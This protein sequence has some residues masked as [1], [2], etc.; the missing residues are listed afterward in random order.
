M[1]VNKEFKD[2]KLY[3]S[4][5]DTLKYSIIDKSNRMLDIPVFD[6][7]KLNLSIF[8]DFCEF[9]SRILLDLFED[10]KQKNPSN[11]NYEIFVKFKKGYTEEINNDILRGVDDEVIDFKRYYY[12]KIDYGFKKHNENTH[13]T[14]IQ[15]VVKHIEDVHNK[16]LEFSKTN[17]FSDTF[18]FILNLEKP[19]EEYKTAISVYAV[20]YLYDTM[21][22]ISSTDIQKHL[23]E[24]VKNSRILLNNDVNFAHF[25]GVI[26]KFYLQNSRENFL[27]VKSEKA[28]NYIGELKI[29]DVINYKEF[30]NSFNIII[31]LWLFM[32]YQNMKTLEI[33]TTADKLKNKVS[34]IEDS[35][36]IVTIIP[37][38]NREYEK[39]KTDNEYNEKDIYYSVVSTTEDKSNENTVVRKIYEQSSINFDSIIASMTEEKRNRSVIS[40]QANYHYPFLDSI[41]N[42]NN[43]QD[44]DF[45]RLLKQFEVIY[46]SYD[47]K[48]LHRILFD[49]FYEIIEEGKKKNTG[50]LD[51]R[52]FIISSLAQKFRDSGIT[53]VRN[54]EIRQNIYIDKSHPTLKEDDTFKK[55]ILL[56]N[57]KLVPSVSS[58]YEVMISKVYIKHKSRELIPHAHET[59]IDFI[60]D[61]VMFIFAQ[62]FKIF[63]DTRLLKTHNYIEDVL[64]NFTDILN[65]DSLSDEYSDDIH[66]DFNQ[67]IDM[68]K[69]GFDLY[70]RIL[71][72][73]GYTPDDI[74]KNQ[75][76]QTK[77]MDSLFEYQYEEAEYNNFSAFLNKAMNEVK[78]L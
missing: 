68:F 11:F 54:T 56:Y 36:K 67:V 28:I 19:T 10:K 58:E 60:T 35:E 51:D 73:I 57:E 50:R 15:T 72:D 17:G 65:S 25:I 42:R 69:K 3:N 64:I 47:K 2:I 8:D 5:Y 26:Y 74:P 38:G 37:L 39:A 24:V 76:N 16:V 18:N 12:N 52:Q 66:N 13:T 77:D 45:I 9:N 75:D 27:N 21:T 23:T 29:D 71:R 70:Y 62:N 6:G 32:I 30:D 40:K 61:I 14:Y 63:F 48:T 78:K 49:S 20:Y 41:R 44:P 22:K 55:G 4:I 31:S 59:L 34:D 46:G 1:D 33:Y 7:V 53:I 43:M